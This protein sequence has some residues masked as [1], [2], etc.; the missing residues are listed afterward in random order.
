[1]KP[2]DPDEAGGQPPTVRKLAESSG[3][4]PNAPGFADQF[5]VLGPQGIDRPLTTPDQVQRVL[6]QFA[7]LRGPPV[8]GNHQWH[9]AE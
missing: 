7:N 4:D 5:R 2:L 6:A 8:K 1:M 9:A 3:I